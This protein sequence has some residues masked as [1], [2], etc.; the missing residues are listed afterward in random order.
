M[1]GLAGAAAVARQDVH[2]LAQRLQ[3]P[4]AAMAQESATLNK[5]RADVMSGSFLLSASRTREGFH[6]TI[7]NPAYIVML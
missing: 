1:S 7:Y 4:V 6:A 5:D 2:V 3:G